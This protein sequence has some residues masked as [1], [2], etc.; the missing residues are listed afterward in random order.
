V[1]IWVIVFVG[2]ALAGLIMCICY[3]VW[4]AHKAAD[5]WSE[6]DM[7]ALRAAEFADLVE[8]I[9]IPERALTPAWPNDR[10][11]STEIDEA[12]AT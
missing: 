12:S 11:I 2:I 1:V 9:Q 7:L 10:L 6:V 3:A 5:V 8:Q 4:L